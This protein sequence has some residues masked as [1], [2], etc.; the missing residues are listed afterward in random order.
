MS[1]PID[2]KIVKELTTNPRW[3]TLMRADE[4]MISIA[5]WDRRLM[6]NPRVLVPIDVQALYVPQNGAETFVHLPFATTTPDGA[7]PEPMPEPFK[8]GDKR[9]AGVHLHWAMPDSLLNGT[10]Y[11]RDP[12]AE[13]RLALAPLPDRWAVLRLLIP[14]GASRAVVAGWIVEA[15][16]TKVTAL[17]DWPAPD[18]ARPVTGKT[19][20]AAIRATAASPF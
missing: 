5:R 7:D 19:I 18:N 14:R 20:A 8:E 6:R 17:A 13:N 16:T 2:P 11:D 15:D 9:P 4:P 1:P 10:L 12:G 3:S